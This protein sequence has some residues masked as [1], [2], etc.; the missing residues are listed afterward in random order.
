MWFYCLVKK[1]IYQPACNIVIYNLEL[2]GEYMMFITT[3][4]EPHFKVV[5]PENKLQM[6]Y[7]NR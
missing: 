7:S 1:I 5:L 4:I 2:K 6:R 3:C